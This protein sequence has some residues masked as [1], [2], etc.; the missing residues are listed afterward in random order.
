MGLKSLIGDG[1]VELNNAIAVVVAEFLTIC[2]GAAS[3]SPP[4]E[5]WL[6]RKL[7]ESPRE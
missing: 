5:K 3:I 4:V 1:E 2:S 6:R 7:H